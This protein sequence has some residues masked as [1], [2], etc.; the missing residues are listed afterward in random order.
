MSAN[1]T[2]KKFKLSPKLKKLLPDH[3]RAG[4]D[5]DL[6]KKA[7]GV[8]ALC[9][10]SLDKV[11]AVTADHRVA[12]GKNTLSNLYLAHKTCNSSRGN[13]PFHIARPIVEFKAYTGENTSVTFNDII[14]DYIEN[15]GKDV[16]AEL[17]SETLNI[18]FGSGVVEL[19]VYSDPATKVKYCFGEVPT[20]CIHNDDEVQPRLIMYQHVRKLALDFVERPVHEPSNCRY[21][22]KGKK[23]GR[24]LQFDGQHKTTAQ[25]LLNRK[26]IPVKIYIEPDIPMLQ[27]LVVKI[28][29]EI[30]KQPLTRSDTIA[31]LGD[32]IKSIL[33]SYS[34]KSPN[35]RTETGFVA[36]Q[37]KEKRA[38]VKKLYYDE[39]ARIVFFDDENEIREWVKPGVEHNPTT[40]KVV[41]DKIIK[42]L[43]HHNLLEIDMDDEGG[44]DTERK[45]IVLVL[46]TLTRK[47]LPADWYVPT[48][49][50]QKRRTTNFFYQGSIV[51]WMQ[52]ILLPTMKY[53]VMRIKKDEPLFV[54]PLTDGQESRVIEAVETLCDWTLWSTE[55]E[56]PLLAMRSNTKK[57][58]I[59]VFSKEYN[60]KKLITEVIT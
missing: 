42:P 48:N 6:W 21:V 18:N 37:P 35:V 20:N 59:D 46:N 5:E 22:K 56:A 23:T 4:A 1:H 47:M 57:N 25:V 9:D 55:E 43:I 51:W 14:K 17:T 38:E 13:L 54:E 30:K 41:I 50:Y 52:E 24:L 7:G 60:E 11:E 8:C 10:R 27:M 26:Q 36:A 2:K 28:Q 12:S 33:D 16:K 45:L 58:M 39:L 3:E 32:V 31:K 44:R 40:D 19:P 29:Q 34:E 53:V 49:K 15:G